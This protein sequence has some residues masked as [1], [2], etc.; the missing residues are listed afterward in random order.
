MLT[1]GQLQLLR[2]QRVN[3]NAAIVVMM[4]YKR[5]IPC[6]QKAKAELAETLDSKKVS[7]PRTFA[8]HF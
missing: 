6:K 1:T 8:Y 7:F 2:L 3:Q 5:L 4:V